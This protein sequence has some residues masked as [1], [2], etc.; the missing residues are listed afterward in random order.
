[1]SEAARQRWRTP[2]ALAAELARRYAGGS[3]DLDVAAEEGASVARSFYDREADGLMQ[4][5]PGRVYC[6]PPYGAIPAWASKA[7]AEHHLE[8]PEVI[9][10][11]L[12]ARLDQVWW[13]RLEAEAELV[14]PVQGRVQFV[15][16]PWP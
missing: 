5:W 6:N 9:V 10:L 15:P 13:H 3:F 1:M 14:V 4:P 7:L 2:P 12:P 16:P 8:R 11:L